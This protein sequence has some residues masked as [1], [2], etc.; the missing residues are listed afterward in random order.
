MAILIR[1]FLLLVLIL[2]LACAGQAQSKSEQAQ[3][4]TQSKSKPKKTPPFPSQKGKHSLFFYP[5]HLSYYF[6][7]YSIN[8]FSPFPAV[9]YVY[10]FKDDWSLQAKLYFRQLEDPLFGTLRSTAEEKNIKLG[11][12]YYCRNRK[13]QLQLGLSGYIEDRKFKYLGRNEE[14]LIVTT[15]G[16]NEVGL[17]FGLGGGYRINE[18]ARLFWGMAIRYGNINGD[19]FDELWLANP[20]ESLGFGYTF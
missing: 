15:S 16:E 12:H 3:T 18:Q 4:K 13:F 5:L 7:Y 19:F 11:I 1:K 10:H 6:D 8:S 17:E 14:K 2:G 9:G 20:V